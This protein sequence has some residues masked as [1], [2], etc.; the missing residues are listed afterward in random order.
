MLICTI[1]NH[2]LVTEHEWK[3]NDGGWT[4]FMA[5]VLEEQWVVF[6]AWLPVL[7]CPW[8]KTGGVSIT[9]LTTSDISAS[10]F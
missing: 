5:S 7:L 3:L 4:T 9:G 8:I 2:L 6:T 10:V 1:N